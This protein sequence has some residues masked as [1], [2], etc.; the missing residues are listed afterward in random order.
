MYTGLRG[1]R[2]FVALPVLLL[3]PALAIAGPLTWGAEELVQ[4]GIAPN[5]A[6]IWVPGY[7][8]PSLA[9]WN[10]DG[11]PDLIV[12]EGSGAV[13]GKVRVYLNDGA[14]GAP[15]FN[16][17]FYVQN[18][19]GDLSVPG[20]GCMGTFPRVVQWD[21]DGKK[22]L[23]IG[24]A[25]GKVQWFHNLG[26]DAAPSYNGGTFVQ[27]GQPG[28]KADINVGARATPLIVDWNGD[29]KKDLVIGDLNGRIHVFINQAAD[30]NAEPD[31]RTD[32]VLQQTGGGDLVVPSTAAPGR[33]SP[34]TLDVDRDGVFDLVSGDTD[35]KLV[36]YRNTGTNAAP[37]F[38]TYSLL[39]ANGVDIDLGGTASAL[40]SRPFVCDWTGDGV[41]DFLVGY[42]DGNI[43]LFQ[44]VPEPTSLALMVV[45][46]LTLLRRR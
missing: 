2:T 13:A 43:H 9:D 39:Q 7:S 42:G 26:T 19:V 40:R 46:G 38:G 24:Q 29:G 35:G 33:A 8:V 31:F 4:A 16:N 45:G 5:V 17:P 30:A 12:G 36:Y 41:P 28:S 27:V 14:P 44:G 23:V 32:A 25:D 21:G 10:N 15:H 3:G 34:V 11:L 37:A 6:P 22:D 18:G 1:V 20:S